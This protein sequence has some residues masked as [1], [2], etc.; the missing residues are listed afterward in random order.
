[1]CHCEDKSLSVEFPL[2]S[3]FNIALKKGI[4]H[5]KAVGVLQVILP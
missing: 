1:M 2:Q 3:L 5:Q 4:I